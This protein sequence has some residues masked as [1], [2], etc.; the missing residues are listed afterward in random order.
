MD[1]MGLSLGIELGSTRI[2]GVII[3]SDYRTL[4]SGDYTWE[5]KFVDQ[6]WTYDLDEVWLALADVFAQLKKRFEV[7][8]EM[9]LSRV[10]SIGISGMMHGYLAFDKDG[11]QLVPFR[12]WRNTTTER[13]AALLTEV[14][15]FNIPQRWSVAH[16][17]EAMLR[18]E[19]HVGD[20]DFITTLS[21]YVHW[22]LTG[23]R[24][25]GVGDASGMFPIDSKCGNYD[26]VMVEKFDNLL[27]D[28]HH[29]W[30]FADIFPEVL[31]AGDEA[32]LLT[33]EGARLLDETGM[34]AAGIPLCPPEGDAGTGMVAT[35]SVREHTGNVSAGTSIFT[36]LV[37]EEPLSAYYTEIDMV[38][39]PAGDDVAMVH[40][41]NFTSDI[42]AWSDLFEEVLT[43]LGMEVDQQTLMT[44]LFRQALDADAETGDLVHCNYYA[45][46]PIT[47]MEA[48]RPLFA[49][50]P[51]SV[52]NLPNFM[53]SHIYAALA[54]LKIGM[55]LLTEKEKVQVDEMIGH[56]GF[57]KTE[58]V[59]QQF[60]A[61]ALQT[62]VTLMD[63][64]EEGGAW[65]IAILA[66]YLMQQKK[67]VSLADYLTEQVF[68]AD[69]VKT[70]DPTKDGV[71]QF[72]YYMEKYK[73]ILDVE[74][75]AIEKLHE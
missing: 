17:Y 62:P 26:A 29:D 13:A 42:N 44:T 45:G 11:R 52:F 18:E 22:K 71:D 55:D 37:L 69:E 66:N 59:G 39:T 30:R 8:Y 33:E 65:G 47:E 3:D 60:M 16:L 51:D 15:Q 48:G 23:E 72:A 31:V 64:A 38:S 9:P 75:V 41:N 63:T 35:N 57:F 5:N 27:D 2:K 19:E 4:V 74:R 28:F 7:L 24:V 67:D 73:A 12:T 6:N 34:L 1:L 68:I 43:S 56:G 53:R 58:N 61:D 50:M 40:C 70:L 25:L 32:G 20:V 21:G 49:R 10:G 46:E 54:T 36:M 14:M